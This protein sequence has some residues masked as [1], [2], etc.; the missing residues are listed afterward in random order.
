M[1]DAAGPVEEIAFGH[2]EIGQLACLDAPGNALESENLRR[3]ERERAQRVIGAES[4]FD[5]AAYTI[6]EVSQAIE[7]VRRERD[8]HARFDERSRIAT[9][10]LRDGGVRGDF[11]AVSPTHGCH[12]QLERAP[13]HLVDAWISRLTMTGFASFVSRSTAR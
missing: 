3:S 2:D 9:E 1:T 10:L 12:V 5:C 7:S 13:R 4:R 8:R 6:T 11:G